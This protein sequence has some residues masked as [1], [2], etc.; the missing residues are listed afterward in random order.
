MAGPGLG[1][2]MNVLQVVAMNTILKIKNYKQLFNYVSDNVIPV[3]EVDGIAQLVFAAVA[4]V[5]AAEHVV[6]VAAE[7]NSYK[8]LF[9]DILATPF[10]SVDGLVQQLAYIF[11]SLQQGVESTPVP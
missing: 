1:C 10:D 9:V 6:A 4:N 8:L 7:H 3:T 2:E 11:A 5:T